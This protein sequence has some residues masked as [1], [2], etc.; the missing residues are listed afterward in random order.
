MIKIIK[1]IKQYDERI[2]GFIIVDV[3]LILLSLVPTYLSPL[4]YEKFIDDCLIRNEYSLMGIDRSAGA[5]YYNHIVSLF[6]D[7]ENDYEQ[8]KSIQSEDNCPLLQALP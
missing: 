2:L 7:K 5:W 4:I 3:I 8:E 6:I 1:R